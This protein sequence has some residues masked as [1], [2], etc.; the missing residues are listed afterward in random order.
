LISL[1]ARLA[2]NPDLPGAS[3]VA[4]AIALLDGLTHADTLL[5]FVTR[6]A[7]AAVD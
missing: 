7:Y 6:P 3:R 2:A 5:D 4:D 1:P